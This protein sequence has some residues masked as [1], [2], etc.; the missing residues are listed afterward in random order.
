MNGILVS[1]GEDGT[2]RCWDIRKSASCL[3]SFDQNK[4]TV[5]VPSY[6]SSRTLQS[7]RIGLNNRK[8]ISSSPSSSPT[9]KY[10]IF[11]VTNS[12]SAHNSPVLRV[13]F[14]HD[15]NNLLSLSS[16]DHLRVWDVFSV[17]N[18]LV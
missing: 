17:S 1:G 9:S 13:Q 11:S 18:T 2:I 10:P 5:S 3:Y 6:P 15:G 16:D 4:S 7:D 12:P 8:R 14:T